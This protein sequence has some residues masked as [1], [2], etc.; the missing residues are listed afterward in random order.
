[1]NSFKQSQGFH[2][3]GPR[4]RQDNRDSVKFVRLRADLHL[5]E[6]DLA[7]A[8]HVVPVHPHDPVSTAGVGRVEVTDA[9][10]GV[11]PGGA[12]VLG[13]VAVDPVVVVLISCGEGSV[14]KDEAVS[15][16]KTNM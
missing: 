7:C 10:T 15:W 3:T 12:V 4:P 8:P 13:T 14:V 6:G 5:G 2:A 11:P 9:A 1:M 16:Q